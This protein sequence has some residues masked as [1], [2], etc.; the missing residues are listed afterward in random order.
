M[1]SNKDKL[2]ER[3]I[4]ALIALSVLSLVMLMIS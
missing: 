4:I 2:V 3:L 1:K